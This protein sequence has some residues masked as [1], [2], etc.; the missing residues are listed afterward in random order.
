MDF[1]VLKYYVQ[2]CRLI[3]VNPSFEGLT[4]FKK[5]YGWECNNHGRC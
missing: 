4:K 3:N 1:R 5:F 2:V